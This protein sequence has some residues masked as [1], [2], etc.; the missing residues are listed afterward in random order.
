MSNILA[1][2]HSPHFNGT[3]VAQPTPSSSTQSPLAL[4]KFGH[5]FPFTEP[6]TFTFSMYVSN[7]NMYVPPNLHCYKTITL[8]NKRNLSVHVGKHEHTFA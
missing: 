3:S 8:L 2:R 5:S 4:L 6:N 1:P 7:I